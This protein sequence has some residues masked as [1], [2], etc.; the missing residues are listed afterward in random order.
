[1]E[2]EAE[3]S[4]LK[5]SLEEEHQRWRSSQNNYERQVLVSLKKC[6]FILYMLSIV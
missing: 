3:V 2:M 6:F 5:Q 1:M 4:S